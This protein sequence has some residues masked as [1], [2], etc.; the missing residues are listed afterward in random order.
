MAPFPAY[1][2]LAFYAGVEMRDL[3]TETSADSG[4]TP[5]QVNTLHC[6]ALTF[7]TI[8]VASAILAFY[9]FV[10]MQRSFRHE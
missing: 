8:S 2:G 5:S 7:A 10:K 1:T 4:F 6:L 3:D 9:W